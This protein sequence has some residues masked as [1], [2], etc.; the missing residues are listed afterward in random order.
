MK[1]Y[2]NPTIIPNSMGHSLPEG[3][4]HVIINFRLALLESLAI[5]Y[6]MPKE[7]SDGS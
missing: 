5:S 4:L 3:V 6:L 1:S 2:P 7:N